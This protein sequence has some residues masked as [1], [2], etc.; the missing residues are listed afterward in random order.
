MFRKY[1][2]FYILLAV[3]T[4][5]VFSS[6]TLI[7]SL[8]VVAGKAEGHERVM[9]LNLIASIQLD[10]YPESSL[11]YSQMAL[12]ASKT[13]GNLLD[14]AEALRNIGSAWVSLGDLGKA[15][16]FLDEAY[17]IYS[18]RIGEKGFPCGQ[19]SFSQHSFAQGAIRESPGI[20]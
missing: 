11:K 18:K 4:D 16:P 5:P 14:R 10:F 9:L 20:P 13:E 1:F 6:G 19:L 8:M 17:G 12:E 7:D 15:G 3:L 2:I